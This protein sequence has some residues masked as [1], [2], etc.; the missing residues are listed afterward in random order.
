MADLKYV[1]YCGL[2]CKLCSKTGRMPQLAKVMQDTMKKDHKF[3]RD[4]LKKGDLDSTPRGFKAFWLWLEDLAN[5]GDP[6][7]RNGFCNPDCAIMKCAQEKGYE[8]CVFC[9]DYPCTRLQWLIRS[10]PGVIT[11]GK[12]LKEMGIDAW[13]EE[14]EQRCQRGVC[15][16]G[17]KYVNND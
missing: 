17:T 13:I 9:E 15:Y 4:A 11:D 7:C 2:Y 1:T 3:I 16:S 12:M 5:P 8:I 6:G 14:Q 10:N